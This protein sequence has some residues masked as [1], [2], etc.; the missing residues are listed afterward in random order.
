M[1]KQ[2]LG[3]KLFTEGMEQNPQWNE[4]E[5]E[6]QMGQL[7]EE[8]E[9]DFTY[10]NCKMEDAVW[11][12]QS[13]SIDFEGN[14]SLRKGR[15]KGEDLT[16]LIFKLGHIYGDF[17]CSGSDNLKSLKGGPKGTYDFDAEDCAL[18]S[19]E[20]SPEWVRNFNVRE[21]LIRGLKGCPKYVFGDFN[22]ADNLIRSLDFGPLLITGTVT[23]Q[24]GG[25]NL[26]FEKNG[27][28]IIRLFSEM[29][30]FLTKEYMAVGGSYEVETAKKIEAD[31]ANGDYA[32]KLL[33]ENPDYEIF[34][35]NFKDQIKHNNYLRP[36]KDIGIF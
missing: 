15:Y 32:F 13:N 3:Y 36:L 29:H 33:V 4:D 18:E 6:F 8:L 11:N 28:S 23:I 17:D 9:R 2:I 35:S 20:G 31:I 16:D 34:L 1:Q 30:R 19:L 12:K 7:K 10:L 25:H 24:N 26:R 14:V 22:L 5:K 27:K 21:N